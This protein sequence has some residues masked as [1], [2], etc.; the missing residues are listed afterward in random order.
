MVGAVYKPKDLLQNY[1]KRFFKATKNFAKKRNSGTH[2][3]EMGISLF[4]KKIQ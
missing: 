4:Y 3:K 2:N 1:G